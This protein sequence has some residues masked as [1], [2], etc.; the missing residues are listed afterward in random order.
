MKKRLEKSRKND[1]INIYKKNIKKGDFVYEINRKA[2]DT[3]E[4]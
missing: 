1:I 3:Q 4:T 2:S